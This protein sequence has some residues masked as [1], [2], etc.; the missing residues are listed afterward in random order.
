MKKLVRVFG[1]ILSISFILS[2]CGGSSSE[3]TTTETEEVTEE[4]SSSDCDQFLKDYESFADSYIAIVEKMKANP[5]DM[6]VMTEYTSMMTKLTEMQ[7]GGQDCTDPEY[8]TKMSEIAM[9]ITNAA[10]AM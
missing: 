2:S 10:A 1:L 3:T 4:A 6:S 7:S 5:T 8:V 9:K